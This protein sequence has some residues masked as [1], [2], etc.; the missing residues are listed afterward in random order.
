MS[1][2]GWDQLLGHLPR[3]TG[4]IIAYSE[5]MPSPRIGWRPYDTD[6]PAPRVPDNPFGWLVSEREEASGVR[7]GLEGISREVLNAV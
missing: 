2:Q 7:P 6:N 4:P 3:R 1:N 5:F